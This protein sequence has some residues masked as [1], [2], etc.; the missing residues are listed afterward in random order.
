MNLATARNTLRA[1][2]GYP[3]ESDQSTSTLTRILN[4]AYREIASKYPFHEVRCI[5]AFSTTADAPRYDVP[6]DM[7]ALF[8]VWD[9]TNKK[10]LLKKGVRFL[11]SL[12]PN[13]VTGKPIYYIREKDWIQLVPT[14]DASYSV[15]IFYL[16]EIADLIADG[17]EFVLPLPW[18]DGIV[19]KARHLY[20][21][22]RGDIGKAIYAKN[23]WKD[24]VADKPSE[25][26]LEKDDLEDSGVIVSSLGGEYSRWM[27]TPR[28]GDRFDSRGDFD[29]R[30]Y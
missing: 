10:K 20:Y 27:G 15:Q 3:V 7:A 23:E 12:P 26:D 22:E 4:A 8:R 30:D 9:D 21:D 19:L 11:A 25:I 14:P 2:T 17:D 5:K 18:H 16:T 13:M 1:K 28:A 6:T 24:W 29:T